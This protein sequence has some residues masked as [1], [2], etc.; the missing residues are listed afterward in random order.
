MKQNVE[1][2]MNL[3][4]IQVLTLFTDRLLIMFKKLLH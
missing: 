4:K 1:L 2:K 3:F